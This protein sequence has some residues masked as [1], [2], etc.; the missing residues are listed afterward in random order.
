[1]AEHAN[2]ISKNRAT[3]KKSVASKLYCPNIEITD[4][5][6]SSN[7][8]TSSESVVINNVEGDNNLIAI[9][10]LNLPWVKE[11]YNEL[12]VKREYAKVLLNTQSKKYEEMRSMFEKEKKK[13]NEVVEVISEL[14]KNSKEIPKS[15]LNIVKRYKESAEKLAKAQAEYEDVKKEFHKIEKEMSAIENAYKE[16]HIIV[17][18][19][20]D[21]NNKVVFDGNLHRILADTQNNVKI[22]VREIQGRESIVIEPNNADK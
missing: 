11:K 18:G 21:K 2:I 8:T 17:R 3:I 9:Q 19:R 7:I 5:M 14:K 22:Y 16:G 20:I 1:M 6:M 4:V 10:P 13:Y 12:G 15:L